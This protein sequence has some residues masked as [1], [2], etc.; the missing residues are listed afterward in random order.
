MILFCIT[1]AVMYL[2]TL[3]HGASYE[4]RRVPVQ[5]PEQYGSFATDG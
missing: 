5:P 3:T 1:V 2:S 4:V